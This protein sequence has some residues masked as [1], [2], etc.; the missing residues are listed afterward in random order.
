MIPNKRDGMS[1]I[2][3]IKLPLLKEGHFALIPYDEDERR[4]LGEHDFI[5][6]LDQKIL[7]H[8]AELTKVTMEEE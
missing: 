2:G 7:L 8:L 1:D 5:D 4:L 3:Y 6:L